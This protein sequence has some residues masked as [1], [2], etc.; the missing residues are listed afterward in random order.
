MGVSMKSFLSACTLIL[1]TTVAQ[2][3]FSSERITLGNLKARGLETSGVTTSGY[4][5]KIEVWPSQDGSLNLQTFLAKNG[6][7]LTDYMQSFSMTQKETNE[8]FPSMNTPQN[9]YPSFFSQD[10]FIY[11]VTHEKSRA[12]RTYNLVFMEINKS[13]QIRLSFHFGAQSGYISKGKFT[14]KGVAQTQDPLAGQVV[15]S[16]DWI[17]VPR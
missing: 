2:A 17:P 11:F 13:S 14:E 16:T 3:Q 4:S 10:G 7:G 8:S 9:Q 15:V 5:Y 12:A 1:I 6:Q